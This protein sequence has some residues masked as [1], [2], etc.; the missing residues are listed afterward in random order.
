MTE[1]ADVPSP[2]PLDR[3]LTG[4]QA[5]GVVS[6][7]VE[8]GIFDQ[9]ARGTS[10]L[11]SLAAKI[12]ADKRGTRILLDA[13]AALSLVET[14][15]G[16]RLSPMADSFLVSGRPGYMGR[17]VRFMSEL[18]ARIVPHF[19]AAV[20]RGGTV[21]EE[22]ADQ[23]ELA[24]WEEFAAASGAMARVQA[25]ALAGLLAPWA[26]RRA[27]LDVL[28][29]ACG[30]GLYSLTLVARHPGARVTLNDWANVLDV[31]RRSV[32]RLG[33]T[34]LTAYLPGDVFEVDLG[35]PYDLI[36][37]SNCFHMFSEERCRRL[38]GRLAGALRADGRVAIQGPMAA[39]SPAEDPF[40]RLFSLLI[41]AMSSGGEAH[42]VAA[43]QRM[44]AGA[45]LAILGVHDLPGLA[46]SRSVL[47]GH[48][49]ARRA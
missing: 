12:K 16:Y 6:A 3:L 9:L 10:D 2:E 35:G 11:A 33:L 45:G 30:S 43:Y 41:L 38:L 39:G 24:L 26:N 19:A 28:D 21:L 17:M 37:A 40:P 20:R 8:L 34:E 32:E 31:T 23:P 22:S 44:V 25:D 4:A 18:L 5:I 36:V 13:L 29:V 14:A 42:P 48:P 49:P 46:G 15:D 47:A 27:T 1:H 7:A